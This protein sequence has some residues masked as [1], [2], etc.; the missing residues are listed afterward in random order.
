M[1]FVLEFFYEM[2]G[3]NTRDYIAGYNSAIVVF[4]TI[5]S[6]GLGRGPVSLYV[7]I[8]L[9]A[10]QQAVGMFMMSDD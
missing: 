7:A 1:V 6:P 2:L 4:S 10:Y 3:Y 5:I 8:T 9:R